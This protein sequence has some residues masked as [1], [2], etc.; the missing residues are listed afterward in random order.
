MQTSL[1]YYLLINV[2]FIDVVLILI[3]ME[4]FLK[5]K[6]EKKEKNGNN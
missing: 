4:Q 5:D 6:N 2:V 1:D 3:I